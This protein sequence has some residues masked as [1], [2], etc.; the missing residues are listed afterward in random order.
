MVADHR[1]HGCGQRSFWSTLIKGGLCF[2]ANSQHFTQVPQCLLATKIENL[3][4]S[5]CFSTEIH[6][7][8]TNL[9]HPLSAKNSANSCIY[10]S[11][12]TRHDHML[13]TQKTAHFA[14]SYPGYWRASHE[15]F[16]AAS[17]GFSSI[18]TWLVFLLHQER[19]SNGNLNCCLSIARLRSPF[20]LAL[21][22]GYHPQA[23]HLLLMCTVPHRADTKPRFCFLEG[24]TAL[25]SKRRNPVA[26]YI[27]FLDMCSKVHRTATHPY[28]YT[29]TNKPSK[30]IPSIVGV[31]GGLPRAMNLGQ[32][33]SLKMVLAQ[34][35]CGRSSFNGDQAS[36]EWRFQ[37]P[38][39][40]VSPP[41]LSPKL[42][43]EPHLWTSSSRTWVPRVP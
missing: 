33:R 21:G 19:T 16:L 14:P 41:K 27:F 15:D 26:S 32:S 20:S 7:N 4:H 38:I 28:R 29:F 35:G 1:H 12:C 18:K 40:E 34:D 37:R 6:I 42:A 10:Q 8:P 9:Y 11:P 43:A 22:L 2:I 24:V 39:A 23:R 31:A 17:H 25:H 3:E 30:G 5:D 13:Q 36:V